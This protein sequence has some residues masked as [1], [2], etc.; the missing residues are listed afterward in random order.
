VDRARAG[1]GPALIV[2][3]TYRWRGHSKSDRNRYRTQKEIDAWK[4]KDP[5]LK[6]REVIFNKKL[7]TEE[8]ADQIKEKG[9]ADI[10]AARQFAEASPEPEVSTLE[11][12][13]YAPW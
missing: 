8:E 3:D 9:Y 5:I 7:V 2:N 10:E 1:K 12:G 13:V 11:E 4:A 6:F